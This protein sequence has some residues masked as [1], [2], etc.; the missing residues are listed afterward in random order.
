MDIKRYNLATGIAVFV[1]LPILFYGF[2]DVPRRSLLKEALS[3]LTLLSFSFMLAQFFLA[4]S[5]ETVIRQYRLKHVLQTHKVIAYF[6]LTAF[7]VHPFL[8]VVPRYFEAG[9]APLDALTTLLTTFDSL[10]VLLGM[11]AW[12]LL[13]ILGITAMFRFRLVGILGIRYI[14]WRKFHGFLVT[15]F[16]FIAAWHAIELGRH[17][18][19]FMSAFIVL[20][21]VAG[22]GLLLK[23]YLS[24]Y[25]R[26]REQRQ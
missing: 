9:V 25:L 3:V 16:I 22:I 2:G 8:I 7:L 19:E 18:D 10:G 12:C 6:V 26:S 23:M 21:A 17:T 20:V 4:R 5:N 1:A 13:L 14:T 15:A 24:E 11:V